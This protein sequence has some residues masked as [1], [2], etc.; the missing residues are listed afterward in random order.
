MKTIL[1]VI[2]VLLNTCGLII[3]GFLLYYLNLLWIIP[4]YVYTI[5][6]PSVLVF[7]GCIVTIFFI[8]RR[9]NWIWGIGGV[10]IATGVMFLPFTQLEN[11]NISSVMSSPVLKAEQGKSLS[12]EE[13]ILTIILAHQT[14]K[15]DKY[16]VVDPEAR[17]EYFRE[18]GVE[19]IE[20]LKEYYSKIHQDCPALVDRLI[21]VNKEPTRLTLESSQSEGYLIDYD[22]EFTNDLKEWFTDWEGWRS[23]H[24]NFDSFMSVSFPA[25]D[26]QTGFVLAY[27]GIT[28]APLL[29]FGD[30]NLY[31]YEN[32]KMI[33]IDSYMISIS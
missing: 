25:Y 11:S 13:R 3:S 4:R 28:A 9:K 16:V 26:P 27:V 19:D 24:P 12:E 30:L 2:M 20:Y 22:G 23:S 10:I 31:I 14:Y 21:E 18:Y 7:L 33:L 32:G 8:I 15:D 5:A 6:L 29:G 1:L 17:F